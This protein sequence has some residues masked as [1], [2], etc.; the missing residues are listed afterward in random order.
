MTIHIAVITTN[1]GADFVCYAINRKLNSALDFRLSLI[2]TGTLSAI[3]GHTVDEIVALWLTP[4]YQIPID[5]AMM[6]A[7]PL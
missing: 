5:L 6:S 3:H 7:R 1:K 4:D 2:A